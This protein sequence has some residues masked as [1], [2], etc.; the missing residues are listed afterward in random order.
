MGSQRRQASHSHPAKQSWFWGR[1]VSYFASCVSLQ[2]QGKVVGASKRSVAELAFERPSTCVFPIVPSQLIWPCKPPCTAFPRACIW[3]LSCV[4]PLMRFEVAA[5]CVDLVASWVIALV[6]TFHIVSVSSP[7]CLPSAWRRLSH[8]ARLGWF[9]ALNG[10]DGSRSRSSRRRGSWSTRGRHR[11]NGWRASRRWPLDSLLGDSDGGP[12]R[13]AAR[14][15][16]SFTGRGARTRTLWRD[17]RSGGHLMVRKVSWS[18]LHDLCQ[19][20]DWYLCYSI[21]RVFPFSST[22]QPKGPTASWRRNCY[23]PHARCR[24]KLER[25]FELNIGWRRW[26]CLAVKMW[27]NNHSFGYIRNSWTLDLIIHWCASSIH[28]LQER[29][30]IIEDV[31]RNVK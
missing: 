31:G 26:C 30:C 19:R 12:H 11:R 24:S 15:S 10:R 29:S 14:I 21:C 28:S 18:Q 1:L 16:V 8:A 13:I 17:W 9:I 20:W 2:V 23:T 5:L 6:D 27:R 22:H 25:I 7:P 3:L 4:W